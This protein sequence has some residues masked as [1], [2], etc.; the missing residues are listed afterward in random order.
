MATTADL[1][2]AL[3]R[4]GLEDDRL[5]ALAARR[6]GAPPVELKAMDHLLETGELTPSELSDRLALTSGAVTALVDRLV[7][8]GW[9]AR[10]PHPS[11]RR[12]VIIKPTPPKSEAEQI[13]APFAGELARAA[14]R[15]T[16][17]ERDAAVGFLEEAAT[18]ARAQADRLKAP[19][20][21]DPAPTG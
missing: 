7:R 16:A 11:D 4:Y 17:G 12:S 21:S 8:L 10:E 6:V 15:L 20:G 1:L 5:D 3:R 2:R 18:A 13:Y 14:A 19:P 9:V